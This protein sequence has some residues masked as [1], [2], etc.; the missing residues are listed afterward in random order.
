M[1]E[2]YLW[3]KPVN[4]TC[5]QGAH[6]LLYLLGVNLGQMTPTPPWIWPCPDS[7]E[8]KHA[9]G[10]RAESWSHGLGCR[11]TA[12]STSNARVSI[13]RTQSSPLRPLVPWLCV[14]MC[15]V[16]QP[17]RSSSQ[18]IHLEIAEREHRAGAM[19]G[20]GGSQGITQPTLLLPSLH[21]ICLLHFQQMCVSAL[22]KTLPDGDPTLPFDSAS[23]ALLPFPKSQASGFLLAVQTHH[24]LS[25]RD[26]ENRFFCLQPFIYL[27]FDVVSSL[28]LL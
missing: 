9:H 7:W 19:E 25:L 12:P 3:Q 26:L 28:S 21:Q 27:K 24:F 22:L 8:K 17:R 5:G 14:P 6:H 15:N 20:W 16:G 18:K 4:S 11:C 23:G 13:Q 2:K 10:F 1:V